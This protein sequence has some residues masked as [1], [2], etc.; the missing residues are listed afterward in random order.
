M[1]LDARL[2]AILS[3]PACRGALQEGA[4]ELRCAACGRRYPVEAGIPDLTVRTRVLFVCVENSCRSQMAEGFA[5][6]LGGESWEARSAGS[7]PSGRVDPKSVAVMREREIDISGQASKAL[8]GPQEG[9][10]D[11]VV[12]MGCGDACPALA[13]RK[14]LDWDLPDPKG[15]SMDEFRR[16]RDQI[17]ARVRELIAVAP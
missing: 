6:A 3:C 2:L 1:G 11:F 9:P 10:W 14:R 4:E 5:R 15:L 12:T 8:P 17:E 16:L 7:R 13:A